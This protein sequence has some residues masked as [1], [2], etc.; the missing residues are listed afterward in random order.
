M[1]TPLQKLVVQV[2]PRDQSSHGSNGVR[3]VFNDSLQ[4]VIFK[5]PWESWILPE[6][7]D[8]T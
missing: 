8:V 6:Q 1:L 2:V 4:L 5:F 7:V 3:T